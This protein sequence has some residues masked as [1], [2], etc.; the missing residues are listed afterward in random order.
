VRGADLIKNKPVLSA[1]GVHV[2]VVDEVTPMC[3]YVRRP[4]GRTVFVPH[5]ETKRQD[6]FI[7]LTVPASRLEAS[8]YREAPLDIGLGL[9]P[10]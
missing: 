7:A 2:G 9:P 4:D 10:F 6:G 8:D 5:R 3:L 1:D